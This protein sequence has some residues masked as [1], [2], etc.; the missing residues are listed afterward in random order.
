MSFAPVAWNTSVEQNGRQR[1]A[2]IRSKWINWWDS[3]RWAVISDQF[4]NDSGRMVAHHIPGTFSVP[5]FANGQVTFEANQQYDVFNKQTMSSQSTEVTWVPDQVAPVA[6]VLKGNCVDYPNAFGHGIHLRY[7]VV[8]AKGLRVARE[9]VFTRVPDGSGAFVEIPWWLAQ[10]TALECSVGRPHQSRTRL[11]PH[12][13]EHLTQQGHEVSF[14]DDQ[15][16]GYGVRSAKVWAELSE[17]AYHE[18]PIRVRYEC[19]QPGRFRATKYIPREF[20][21]NMLRAG[22]AEV[23]SDDT[24]TVHP[25]PNPETNTVDGRA[26]RNSV[27]ESWSNIR[28]GAG[29]ND[30][31][32]SANVSTAFQMTET[33]GS[34]NWQAL[35]RMIF[36]FDTSALGSESTIDD[37]TLSVKGFGTAVDNHS[38]TLA[39]V[40]SAPSSNTSLTASDYGTL[41]S[42]AYSAASTLAAWG[43]SYNDFTLNASGEAAV[44]LTGITKLGIIEETY[45][46]GASSPTWVDGATASTAG[47]KFAEVSGTASDPKLVVNY[48]PGSGAIPPILHHLRQQGICG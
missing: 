18:R 17:D 38:G 41:G 44:S 35:S 29:T 30:N 42:T 32:S 15:H 43:T 12:W 36:L 11:V 39:V 1:T 45:D 19:V 2:D 8:Q 28:T 10:P 20:I 21:R 23:V 26:R 33:T 16:R 25:D 6:G 31:D 27:S 7:R 5:E 22:A 14:Q 48:T 13:R 37:A 24:L 47:A 9:V 40:S 4:E 3:N 46:L 34:G